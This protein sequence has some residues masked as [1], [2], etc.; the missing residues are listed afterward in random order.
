MGSVDVSEKSK[1]YIT[2]YIKA[3]LIIWFQ[4]H[5]GEFLLQKYLKYKNLFV[6]RYCEKRFLGCCDCTKED[7]D[8]VFKSFIGDFKEWC[9][10]FEKNE[11]LSSLD[12]MENNIA[13]R[14]K[15]FLNLVREVHIFTRHREEIAWSV[16]EIADGVLC[17]M[18]E[19]EKNNHPVGVTI[20]EDLLDCLMYNISGYQKTA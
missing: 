11:D 5:A 15:T 14:E 10:Q 12:I 4:D 8:V 16:K 1:D 20:E 19:Y 6:Q 3:E 2:E 18:A 13:E 17:H 9:E 7:K